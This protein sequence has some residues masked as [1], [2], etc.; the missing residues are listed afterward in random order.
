VKE[1]WKVTRRCP[2]RSWAQLDFRVRAFAIVRVR[3]LIDRLAPQATRLSLLRAPASRRSTPVT[4]ETRAIRSDHPPP[5]VAHAFPAVQRTSQD[6]RPILSRLPPLRR[7]IACLFKCRGPKR[8]FDQYRR[9]ARDKSKLRRATKVSFSVSLSLS[10]SLSVS[11]CPSLSRSALVGR[12][13]RGVL[14]CPQYDDQSVAGPCDPITGPAN[15]I[16]PGYGGKGDCRSSSPGTP[17]SIS[18]LCRAPDTTRASS[19]SPPFLVALSR[20]GGRRPMPV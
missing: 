9:V 14:V 18:R 19:S 2:S 4:I 7:S 15:S 10:L 1:R 11:L 8:P 17:G 12:R 13:E 16:I 20:V 3:A 5:S 6:T